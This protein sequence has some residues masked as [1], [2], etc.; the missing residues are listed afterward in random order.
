MQTEPL[1]ASTGPARR[2]APTVEDSGGCTYCPADAD[3]YDARLGQS[4]CSDCAR[5]PIVIPDGGAEPTVAGDGWVSTADTQFCPD[6]QRER[7]SCA[8]LADET[9]GSR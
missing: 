9:E 6:C 5:R 4:I 2:E 1:G 8:H 7:V 3:G